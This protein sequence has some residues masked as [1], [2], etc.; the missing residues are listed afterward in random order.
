MLESPEQKHRQLKVLAVDDEPLTLRLLKDRLEA[1]DYE[2]LTADN[3]GE[4]LAIALGAKPDII[5]LDIM[6]PVMDGF[7]VLAKLRAT[8]QGKDMPVIVVTACS[9]IQ[10]LNRAERLGVSSYIVK[11]FDMNEL[12]GKIEDVAGKHVVAKSRS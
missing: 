4:A 7:E 3:G 12:L 6:M 5:L 11:P 9:Q 1:N 2:V 8:E 10:G